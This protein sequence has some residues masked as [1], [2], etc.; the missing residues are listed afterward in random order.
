MHT[1]IDEGFIHV[2]HFL[3]EVLE[4]LVKPKKINR[5]Y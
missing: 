2:V 3:A 1:T 5:V 4:N